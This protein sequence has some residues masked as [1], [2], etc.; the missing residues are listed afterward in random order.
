MK[1]QQQQMFAASFGYTV[2]LEVRRQQLQRDFIN[3]QQQQQQQHMF[4]A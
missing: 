2:T 4:S 1:Q 3:Q